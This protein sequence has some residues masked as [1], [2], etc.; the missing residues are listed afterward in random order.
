MSDETLDDTIDRV[1]GEMT[2]GAADPALAAR[3]RERINQRRW[4]WVTPVLAAASVVGAAGITM[5]LWPQNRLP[6]RTA[7]EL[8]ANAV[9]P[10]VALQGTVSADSTG[11]EHVG[12]TGAEGGT[13]V[14]GGTAVEGG[15]DVEGWSDVEGGTLV[16]PQRTSVPPPIVAPISAIASVEALPLA[17]AALI[18][19]P[20]AMPE[21]AEIEP[22]HVASLQI[23]D[24]ELDQSKEPR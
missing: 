8:A 11:L 14:V 10:V 13:D 3:V 12:G 16:P 17:I 4:A 24:I 9:A 23:A 18:V 21:A 7:S 6:E 2:A 22:L 15:S 19:A 20:L 5:V 1:A